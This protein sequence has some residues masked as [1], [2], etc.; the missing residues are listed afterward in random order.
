MKNT[1]RLITL[2]LFIFSALPVLA[3]VEPGHLPTFNEMEQFTLRPGETFTFEEI[4]ITYSQIP[5]EEKSEDILG[6]LSLKGPKTSVN[7]IGIINPHTTYLDIYNRDY[8]NCICID[9]YFFQILYHTQLG[10]CLEIRVIQLPERFDYPAHWKTGGRDAYLPVTAHQPVQ[11]SEWVFRILD[12]PQT[13]QDGAYLLLSVKNIETGEE[14]LTNVKRGAKRTFG[15]YYMELMVGHMVLETKSAYFMVQINRDTRIRG[16]DTY[17]E[18]LYYDESMTHGDYLDLLGEKYNFKVEWR[19]FPGY[20]ESIELY[21][22]EKESLQSIRHESTTIR[23]FLPRAFTGGTVKDLKFEWK[24][25]NHLIV[26]PAR[27][28]EYLQLQERI[29]KENEEREKA[30]EDFNQ[31]YELI[32]KIYPLKTLSAA[33]AKAL[34]EKEIFIHLLYRHPNG[35]NGK[36]YEVFSANKY[37]RLEGMDSGSYEIASIKEEIYSDDRT[38]VLIVK[39]AAHTHKKLSNAIASMED[40]IQIKEKKSIPQ[41]FR[42]EGILLEGIDANSKITGLTGGGLVNELNK[43]PKPPIKD[44]KKYGL[45]AEDIQPFGFNS[46]SE[47]G[48][49]FVILTAERGEVGQAQFALNETYSCA[50]EFQ[51]IREP[52]LLLKASLTTAQSDKPLLSNSLFLEKNKPAVLGLTNLRQALILILRIQ[53]K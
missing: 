37:N 40:M 44:L 38:N 49:G 45:S 50:L 13:S 11:L 20:P 52:Y 31:E 12:E 39:A 4:K 43:S 15:R 26:Q 18:D 51:D 17:V 35:K 1:I 48:K 14:S 30:L 8:P 9:N 27:Y 21:K 5:E 34:L 36:Y 53:G 19:P 24:T 10:N 16:G 29:K 3:D 22:N 23:E 25:P 32:T 33:T 28:D 46:V 41:S 2:C 6:Y 42:I 7:K 47:L